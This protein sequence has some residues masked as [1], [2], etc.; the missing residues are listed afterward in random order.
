MWLWGSVATAA[1]Y[2]GLP[3]RVGQPAPQIPHFYCLALGQ[4]VPTPQTL[5]FN[6]WP[7]A[8]QALGR[9]GPGPWAG[10]SRPGLVGLAIVF[11]RSDYLYTWSIRLKSLA[12]DLL[13]ESVGSF[14]F[15]LD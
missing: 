4:P 14:T 10:R 2:E 13:L 7:W 15:G 9:P 11:M 12:W 1:S 6:D 3:K 8:G 5:T